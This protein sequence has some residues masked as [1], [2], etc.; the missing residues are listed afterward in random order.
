MNDYIFRSV[1]APY[2]N[3]FMVAKE[4]MGFGLIKFR[5]IFKEFDQFFIAEKVNVLGVELLRSNCAI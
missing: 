4:T 3:Q 2:I 5:V 1:F